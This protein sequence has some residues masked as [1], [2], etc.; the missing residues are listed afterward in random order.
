MADFAKQTALLTLVV[1]SVSLTA[2]AKPLGKGMNVVFILT[3]DQGYGDLSCN[4][5]EHIKTP[6][7]D[8]LAS[9]SYR[10]TNYHTATTSAPTRSGIM[11]GMYCNYVGAWHTVQGRE[12]LS[13]DVPTLPERFKENGYKT[14]MFG[15]WHL[16]DNYP[17][18]PHD[19]GF[20]LALWHKAGG[21]GQTPD[22]WD[23]D[24]YNDTYC[25]NSEPTKVEGYCTDV[26]FREAMQ[27]IEENRDDQLFCYISTN[28]PHAP[29]H[30]EAKYAEPYL[31]NKE[32]TSAN[33][34]G[35]I[36]NIDE[37]VGKLR[38]KLK[39]LGLDENTIVIFSTDNGTASGVDVDKGAHVVKGYNA[40][41]RGKKSMVYD[42]GHR[43]PFMLHIP[44]LERH[45]CDISQLAGYIDIA[46]TLYDLCGLTISNAQPLHGI[47]LASVIENPKSKIDRYLV[48][49]TQRA[50]FLRK[51]SRNCV[52]KDSWRLITKKELYDVSTD[53]GQRNNVAEQHPELVAELS[54]V[55]DDWWDVVSVN[56]DIMHPIPL[57]TPDIEAVSMNL[58]DR[59]DEKNGKGGA[60]QSAIRKG[61]K[62][63]KATYLAVEVTEDGLYTFDLYR[64]PQEADIPLL[65][66]APPADNAFF[67]KSSNGVAISD[68]TSGEVIIG[69][70]HREATLQEKESDRAIRIESVELK[71]GKYKLYANFKTPTETFAA[72]YIVVTK[73]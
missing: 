49:D 73:L 68:I 36:A 12:F 63:S 48:V 30:V 55:Y 7:I 11:S 17:Y 1:G 58:H 64:W 25:R 21:I 69:S 15:K 29:L 50:E 40:G 35:M 41:M 59:H 5:N 42:G 45:N 33:Y 65:G 43:T 34:Y 61:I 6:N 71:R 4:G 37:N 14:A 8:R 38:A 20:D 67:K 52:M 23:N 57:S 66:E 24:Y 44:K 26:F 19:R 32:I 39:E 56:S 27:F 16:G 72:H 31:D 47:S 60:S 54:Q 13:P 53:V 3:D 2:E 9:Q 51:D 62:L 18:R 28:A 22:Y 70:T 10:L 46:P